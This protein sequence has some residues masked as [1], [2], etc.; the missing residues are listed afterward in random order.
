[1]SG[2]EMSDATGEGR[3]GPTS[4]RPAEPYWDDPVYHYVSRRHRW[5][6]ADG[7]GAETQRFDGLMQ[8]LVNGSMPDA[9][10]GQ[11]ETEA[12]AD[13]KRRQPQRKGWRAAPLTRASRLERTPS[14][15]VADLKTRIFN[16]Q[17]SRENVIKALEALPPAEKRPPSLAC[18][19]ASERSWEA[20]SR[21]EGTDRVRPRP[22][23]NENDDDVD[24][25]YCRRPHCLEHI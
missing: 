18:R 22:D 1:M 8:A 5:A 17:V 25:A 3:Q 16:P 15:N 2:H 7:N 13:K 20:I 9:L 21:V 11:L 12:K 24:T 6:V 4:T 23:P 10:Y 14:V 19:R